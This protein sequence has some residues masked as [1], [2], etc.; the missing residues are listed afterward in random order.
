MNSFIQNLRQDMSEKSK[1]NNKE[2]I[3]SSDIMATLGL[4]GN[5]A[6]DAVVGDISNLID[7]GMRKELDGY[8]FA[9][10]R[11][12]KHDLAWES[13]NK[14]FHCKKEPIPKKYFSY[15]LKDSNDEKITHKMS[16]S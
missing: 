13:I 3:L 5:M 14:A 7:A 6:Q 12:M 4:L 16:V 15:F 1:D 11:I 8:I 10:S 2:T 9:L